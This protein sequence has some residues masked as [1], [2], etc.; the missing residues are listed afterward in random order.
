MSAIDWLHLPPLSALK[1]FE[2]TAR[3][4][5]FSSAA[6]ALNVT[7][8]A[9]AQ[10]VRA[11]EERL[12]LSLAHREGRGLRLTPEGEDLAQAL[13][14]GFATIQSALERLRA[15]EKERPVTV[16][17]T[18]VFAT[19]W[20]MPRLRHFWA[21]HPDVAI[22][23]RPDP[24]VLDLARERIDVGIRYGEGEWPGVEARLLTSARYVIVGAPSLLGDRTGLTPDELAE[25]PWVLEPDWPE[26]RNWLSC[27]GGVDPAKLR[28]TEFA[29]E[30]LALTAARQGYGLQVSSKALV[31]EDVR[32]GTLRIVLAGDADSPGYY[33]VTP[34]GPLRPAARTFIRWLAKSV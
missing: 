2:A 1:A 20:L 32:K 9:V 26:Q 18:P 14:D 6:R 7:H 10:Q 12:G 27:C 15:G 8:A 19:N 22:S 16:T 13:N 31:E 29:T 30:E 34:P 3:F 28:I 11:L 33:T 25:L 24:N 17:L 5:G 4:R 23:L 21:A